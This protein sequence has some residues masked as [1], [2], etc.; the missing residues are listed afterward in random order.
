MTPPPARRTPARRSPAPDRTAD[1]TADLLADLTAPG[2]LP[3]APPAPAPSTAP[4]PGGTPALS[5]TVTPLRWRA[6]AFT[7]TTRGVCVGV[8]I[9]PLRVEVAI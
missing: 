2:S 6:P 8:R 1:L 5:V 4:T 9:G 7:P 3:S